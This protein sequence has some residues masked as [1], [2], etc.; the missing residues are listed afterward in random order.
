MKFTLSQNQPDQEPYFSSK[1]IGSV[2]AICVLPFILNQVGIDFGSNRLPFD[3]SLQQA[4][5][6]TLTDAMHKSLSGSFTHTILE[7]S[8]FC[9]AI[10][11]VIFSFVHF[12]IR[13]D[14]T[15]PII[16]VA[17]FFA[18]SMDAFHSCRQP[19]H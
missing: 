1:I 4:G 6:G 7:W 2:I 16:G 3:P 9:T 17:L 19:A 11:I 15:T 12:N 13:K 5:Q 10:F 8:A 18:G 14:V